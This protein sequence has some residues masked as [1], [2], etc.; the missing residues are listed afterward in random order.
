MQRIDTD[1]L[2][3]SGGSGKACLTAGWKEAVCGL[4]MRILPEPGHVFCQ[5]LKSV[6]TETKPSN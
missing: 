6:V 5:L 4:P 3:L 2:G 1:P